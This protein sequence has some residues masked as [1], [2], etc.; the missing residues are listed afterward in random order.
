[1]KTPSKKLSHKFNASSETS[2]MET[3][4]SYIL[5]RE[6]HLDHMVRVVPFIVF[7]YAVQSFIILKVSPTDFSSISL[8]IL[9]GFLAVMIGTFVLYDLKH[10]VKFEETQLQIIFL[11]QIK[12]I[13]YHDISSVEVHDPNQSF[14]SLTIKGHSKKHTFY[15]VDDA[16][17]IKDWIETRQ[18][19][20]QKAA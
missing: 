10:Q 4:N 14:S 11:G 17:K 20:E 1:M 15:F 12:T 16:E 2:Y 5:T 7:C 6:K 13:S 18:K 3:K 8:S 19:I 9:G